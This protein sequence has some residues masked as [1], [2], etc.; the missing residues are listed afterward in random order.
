M[1][2]LLPRASPPSFTAP[3]SRWLRS[4]E[5]QG[6]AVVELAVFMPVLLLLITGLTSFGLTVSTYLRLTDATRIGAEQLA[7]DRYQTL[8]AC[9]TVS[10]AVLA[11]VP[12]LTPSK[13]TFALVLNGTSY[14]G[15]TCAS[16][17]YS[18]GA[19]SK[20]V[21]NSAATLTVTYPCTLGLYKVAYHSCILQAQTTELIQ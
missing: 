13:L 1:A 5:E 10:S 3:P 15:T 11:A 2:G 4:L 12:Q 16:S 21:E 14:T 19:S 8:D 9:N 18:S 17:T 20:L 6:Q 7:I